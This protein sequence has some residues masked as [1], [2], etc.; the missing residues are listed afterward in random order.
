MKGL[1]VKSISNF[2]IAFI[3]DKMKSKITTFVK[4]GYKNPNIAQEWTNWHF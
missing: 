2:V 1:F 4:S 3:K